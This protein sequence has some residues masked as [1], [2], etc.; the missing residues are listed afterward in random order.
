[1][2]SS[3]LRLIDLA[4]TVAQHVV[5]LSG[6]VAFQTANSFQLGVP[7]RHSPGDIRLGCRIQAQP[8]DGDDMQSTIGGSVAA[9]IKAVALCLA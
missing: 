8:P 3:D 5:Q 1:M 4:V 2:S 6:D 9:P 7:L